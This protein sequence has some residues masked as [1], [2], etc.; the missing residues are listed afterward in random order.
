MLT[1]ANIT[2]NV[3]TVSSWDGDVGFVEFG[4]GNSFVGPSNQL[5]RIATRVLSNGEV[6]TF[7]SPCGANCTYNVTLAGP[8]YQ[9][10]EYDPSLP[11]PNL[12]IPGYAFDEYDPDTF[13]Y[14]SVE[15]VGNQ[16]GSDGLWVLYGP[17]ATIHCT[18][19]NA[20][21]NSNINFTNNIPDI[22]TTVDWASP[23]NATNIIYKTSTYALYSGPQ[24]TLGIVDEW[25]ALNMYTIQ[26]AVSSL[27][28]GY[29]YVAGVYGGFSTHDTMI[30]VAN[31]V[32]ITPFNVT[33]QGNVSDLLESLLIN[34]TLSITN[35]LSRP[36][37]P[38]LSQRNISQPATYTQVPAFIS[39]YP[40]KYVYNRLPLWGSYGLALGLATICCVVGG[41]MV[42]R[43]GMVGDLGF[44]QVLIKT[45][46][47]T[48]D[49][50]CSGT[51][52]ATGELKHARLRFGV[53]TGNEPPSMAFGI[54]DEIIPIRTRK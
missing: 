49:K 36:A 20:T 17:N 5:A 54:E 3:P 31:F 39:T 24:N 18:L 46:N 29:I 35:F 12:T 42:W 50:L 28:Q 52:I 43:N 6:L 4:S 45:R 8:A 1:T 23:L 32:D 11:L 48:L 25:E 21:Y 13:P 9:C 41:L 40:T 22:S 37:L 38:D 15:I 14:Y 47:P 10:L 7:P 16:N 19:W 51:M 26:K 44:S 2:A 27:L 34:T 33:F 30:G 53:L